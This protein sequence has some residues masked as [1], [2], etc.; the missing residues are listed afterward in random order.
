VA[1]AIEQPAWGQTRVANELVK[2]GM[3]IS[4][5]GVRSVWARHDLTTMKQRLKAL[6]AKMAQERLILTESQ[7]AALE[8]AKADKEA[9]G[10]F[11][12][13]CPGYCG[14]QDT[15]YV[16]TLKC[17]S[18]DLIG[19]FAVPGVGCQATRRCPMVQAAWIIFSRAIG[20]ASRKVCMG[21]LPKHQRP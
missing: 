12:T 2:R 7:L 15:F 11:D 21:V 1:L 10:E 5:F 17:R 3:S 4:P 13:E 18:L 8:K 20:R 14:A 19:R 6:E 16:G 9:Q